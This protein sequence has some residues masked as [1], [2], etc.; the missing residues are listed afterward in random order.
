MLNFTRVLGLITILLIATAC[1]TSI[2]IQD[3]ELII[4]S[5]LTITEEQIN[6]GDVD[7]LSLDD[8]VLIENATVDIQAGLMVLDGA[9]RCPDGTSENGTVTFTIGTAENGFLD[10]VIT[11][12][13]AT[14]LSMDDAVITEANRALADSLTQAAQD[15]EESDASI[16]F[17]EVTLA[18]DTLTLAFEVRAP[19]NGNSQQ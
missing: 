9:L 4:N 7:V 15:V 6:S 5:S 10:V 11:D 19:V 8:V 13:S 14:C 18:D 3:G 17:T 2:N 1:G 16:T 12:V